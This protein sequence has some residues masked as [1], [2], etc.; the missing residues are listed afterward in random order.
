[1]WKGDYINLGAGAEVGFYTHDGGL[2][3]GIGFWNTVPNDDAP[4]MSLALSGP[5]G[6]I[7]SFDPAAPQA[8]VGAFNSNV[9]DPVASDLSVDYTI[10]FPN[11][12]M[13]DAFQNRPRGS[14]DRWSYDPGSRTATLR[15]R[16]N[17]GRRR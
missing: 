4:D 15:F 5:S 8:W 16:R 6:Q 10:T 3:E 13:Y 9:Q 11:G 1:M 2:G 12:G 17:K 14:D 7:V